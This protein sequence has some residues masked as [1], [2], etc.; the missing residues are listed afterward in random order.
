MWYWS[1]RGSVAAFTERTEKNHENLGQICYVAC[2]VEE[3]RNAF[4][5]FV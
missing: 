5:V 4:N 2:G 1:D 3:I